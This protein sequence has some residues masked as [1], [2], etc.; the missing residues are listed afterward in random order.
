MQTQGETHTAS[1]ILPS[2][3][4]DS[5][6]IGSWSYI[7]CTLLD[8]VWFVLHIYYQIS[9]N[10][11]RNFQASQNLIELIRKHLLLRAS[12]TEAS[13]ESHHSGTS[14]RDDIRLVFIQ[15][16]LP[17]S[18]SFRRGSEG[19]PRGMSFQRFFTTTIRQM[20]SRT[21]PVV[22]IGQPEGRPVIERSK[23]HVHGPRESVEFQNQA[24]TL[25]FR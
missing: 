17:P 3:V 23:I 5:M 8:G 24:A 22:F 6:P 25:R 18:L 16:S 11:R 20:H 15:P 4:K 14:E 13:I 12:S 2:A 7:I 19:N 9:F 21:I 1:I 10:V